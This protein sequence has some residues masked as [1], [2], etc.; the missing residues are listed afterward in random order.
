MLQQNLFNREREGGLS[1]RVFPGVTRRER[2]RGHPVSF[3]FL[4]SCGKVVHPFPDCDRPRVLWLFCASDKRAREVDEV[5]R[6]HVVLLLEQEDKVPIEAHPPPL[7]LHAD[8]LGVAD[9]GTLKVGVGAAE[10][11]QEQGGVL[12][13]PKVDFVHVDQA[14]VPGH[15]LPVDVGPEGAGVAQVEMRGVAVDIAGKDLCVVAGDGLVC[16]G[17]VDVGFDVAAYG[18]LF[19]ITSK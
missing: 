13:G 2:Y 3:L 17:K 10:G 18:N 11:P 16:L 4:F 9:H 7:P 14:L 6:V 19:I 8:A 1:D 5:D 15:L 12:G